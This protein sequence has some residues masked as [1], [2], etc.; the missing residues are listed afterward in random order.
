[1][2]IKSNVFT[3]QYSRTLI[4]VSV[5]T[6][7]HPAGLGINIL[8]GAVDEQEYHYRARQRPQDLQGWFYEIEEA[9]FSSPRTENT[10]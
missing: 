3:T 6:K 7:N 1:M 9:A 10:G 4:K 2:N 8:Q 5:F